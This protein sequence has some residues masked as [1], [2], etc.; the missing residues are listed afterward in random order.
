MNRFL[1]PDQA[2]FL[3]LALRVFPRLAPWATLLRPYGAA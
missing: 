3:T 2:G 1:S